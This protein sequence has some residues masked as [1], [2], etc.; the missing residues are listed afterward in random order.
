[1][2]SPSKSQHKSSKTLKEQFSN[3]SGKEK[4]KRNRRAKTILN[5]KITSGGITIPEFKL[6][7]RA[8]MIKN[9]MVLVQRQ[10]H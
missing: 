2:K 9:C 1:M 4:K 6:Y 7:Y 5:N 3:S 10:T 8:I